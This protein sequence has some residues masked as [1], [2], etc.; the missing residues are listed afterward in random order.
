VSTPK[1]SI[2]VVKYHDMP[3]RQWYMSP[4]HTDWY[5]HTVRTT[6]SSALDQKHLDATLDPPVRLLAL[7]LNSLGYTTLPSCS[8]HYKGAD[9][10]NE[11]Y[12][13]L[14][15]DSRIIRKDGL[16]LLDVENGNKL[17]HCDP[18]WHLPWTRSDF[19]RLASGSDGRPE[20]YL[21]FEVPKSDGYKV[22][23]AVDG[24]VS[25]NKGCRYEVKRTPS[26]YTFELR[27][28]TGK[29]KS[30]DDAWRDLGD[31]VMLGLSK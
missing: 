31:S 16:E 7:G 14:V 12:E 6:P 8:G 19:M 1:V 4:H 5:Y 26:G 11:A 22:G 9:E 21:G 25:V 23:K 10:L 20:G 3:A 28:H 15:S 2:G 29:Q 24:A 13:N 18:S 17:V 30:Q 27:V